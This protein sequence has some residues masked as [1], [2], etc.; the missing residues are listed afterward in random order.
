[1]VAR[2]F[3]P[4][5]FSHSTT[6]SRKLPLQTGSVHSES[7]HNPHFLENQLL[8]E[9]K[10]REKETLGQR[11]ICYGFFFFFHH[12]CLHLSQTDFFYALGM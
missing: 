1:M 3:A 12:S 4:P 5:S 2:G 8:K 6:P 11:G 10:Q 9:G 7:P